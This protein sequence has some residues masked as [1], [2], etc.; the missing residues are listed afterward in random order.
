MLFRLI[1]LSVLLSLSELKEKGNLIR[2]DPD[3]SEFTKQTSLKIHI[4]VYKKLPLYPLAS[5]HALPLLSKHVSS[6]FLAI[7]DAQSELFL[8][9][10]SSCFKCWTVK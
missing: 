9:L 5:S 2:N 1:R 8:L 3:K 6:S 4:L 10:A 7:C